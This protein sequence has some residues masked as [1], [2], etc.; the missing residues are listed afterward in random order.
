KEKVT[1]EESLKKL[2]ELRKKIAAFQSSKALQEIQNDIDEIRKDTSEEAYDTN[3]DKKVEHVSCLIEQLKLKKSTLSYFYGVLSDEINN[4]QSKVESVEPLWRS[5]LN[6]VVREQR[7]SKTGLEFTKKYNTAR[8]TVSVPI[9]RES[10]SASKVASEAQKTDL[11]LTFLLSMALASPWSPWKALLLDD[12]TQ[13]HDLV[14]A[15]AVYDLFR[16]YISEYGFQLIVTT[17]DPVQANFLRRKLESDGIE[18]KIIELVP[19]SGG[20]KAICD[21]ASSLTV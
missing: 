12:P 7:F 19:S 4:I 1:T 3:L 6:R 9:S 5:L 18:A 15:S 17:H 20:V 8:A 14:H 21:D 13:H 16:D 10:V 2:D 11:Q